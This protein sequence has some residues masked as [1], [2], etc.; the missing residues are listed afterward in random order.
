MA[1]KARLIGHVRGKGRNQS[2]VN[3]P[4]VYHLVNQRVGSYVVPSLDDEITER[5]PLHV[6]THIHAV[7]VVDYP[8]ELT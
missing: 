6:V 2:N 1:R 3:I 7:L 5:I 4:I 8:I